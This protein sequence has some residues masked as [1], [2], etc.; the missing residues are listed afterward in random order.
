ML[1]TLKGDWRATD[2]VDRFRTLVDQ[3]MTMTVVGPPA[4][5]GADVL[6]GVREV[7]DQ[8]NGPAI[9]AVAAALAQY[10]T[11]R[12]SASPPVAAAAQ[13]SY[14]L[15]NV[16][17]SDPVMLGSSARLTLAGL[18]GFALL[19]SIGAVIGLAAVGTQGAASYTV[20]G[21]LAG[22]S[23]VALVVL[24]MGYKNVTIRSGSSEPGA[25][26]P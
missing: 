3:T 20:L 21:V 24:V 13:T 15:P 22:L 12:S 25:A 17:L 9:E 7:V 8:G 5:D 18:C 14:G 26:A 11:W 16:T 10:S 4:G 2:P 19:A 1:A 23:L 6:D